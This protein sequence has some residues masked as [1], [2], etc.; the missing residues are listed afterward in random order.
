MKKSIESVLDKENQL[1]YTLL[2]TKKPPTTS[3]NTNDIT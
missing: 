3:T 1:I 2:S